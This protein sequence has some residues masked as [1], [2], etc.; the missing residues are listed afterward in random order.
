MN[1]DA[2]GKGVVYGQSV[3]I[4]GLPVASPLIHIP[5]HVEMKRVAATFSLL[6]HILQLHMGQMH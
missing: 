5:A 4:G 3:Y 1:G 2:A 6:T